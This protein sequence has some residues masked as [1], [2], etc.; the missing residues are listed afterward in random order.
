MTKPI[1]ILVLDTNVLTSWVERTLYVNLA[2]NNV[3]ELHWS[4][5][6]E[7]DLVEKSLPNQGK[8]PE[9]IREIVSALHDALPD[10]VVHPSIRDFAATSTIIDA[11]DR[12]DLNVVA[13]AL[14]AQADYIVTKNIKH[15]SREMEQRFGFRVLHSAEMIKLL[16]EVYPDYVAECIAT[17][18]RYAT[19]PIED[20]FTNANLGE[21]PTMPAKPVKK[22]RRIK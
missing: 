3:I 17:V 6:I 11:T 1:K 8:S 19:K 7:S 10:A 5:V 22:L 18:E 9:Q 2:T 20:L 15:F 12:D 14:A 16:N 13:A 4:A 21:V